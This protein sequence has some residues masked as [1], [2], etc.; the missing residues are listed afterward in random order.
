MN[1]WKRVFDYLKYFNEYYLN[2]VFLS[3]YIF[4]PNS[5][6]FLTKCVGNISYTIVIFQWIRLVR[7]YFQKP[8]KYFLRHRSRILSLTIIVLLGLYTCTS[9]VDKVI[10]WRQSIN[11]ESYQNCYQFPNVVNDSLLDYI[12][13]AKNKP[14]T[15]SRFHF[16]VWM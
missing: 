8:E 9:I 3:I 13:S 1:N 5:Y 2:L 14:E 10:L 16:H 6:A 12:M 11:L 7:M 15:G 4:F